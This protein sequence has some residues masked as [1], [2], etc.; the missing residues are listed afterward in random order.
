[1][2]ATLSINIGL[3]AKDINAVIALAEFWKASIEKAKE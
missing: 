1:L 2:E 3:S